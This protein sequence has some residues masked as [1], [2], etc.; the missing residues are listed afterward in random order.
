MKR[1]TINPTSLAG[2]MAIMVLAGTPMR[3]HASGNVSDITPGV[4]PDKWLNGG[5]NCAELPQDFQIHEYN[6]D[7]VI[8][9][10]SGCVHYEKPF[11][12]LIFGRSKVL[13][14]DTGA[15]NDPNT[16]RNPDVA[17]AVRFVI[18]NWL[19]RNNQSAIHLV[20]THLHSHLDHVY[21]DP[22][23]IGVPNTTFVPPGDV[24]VLQRFFGL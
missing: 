3:L 10:Q 21:G 24:G 19:A 4:L 8:L 16:G 2:A 13:L 23:F 17:G 15:G 9:R 12:F 22:Q 6:P 18:K 11:L 14:L 7:F 5:P 1:D 20:V